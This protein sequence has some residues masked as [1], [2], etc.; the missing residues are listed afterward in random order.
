LLQAAL[1]RDDLLT[2]T[3]AHDASVATRAHQRTLQ[4][5]PQF[6]EALTAGGW[7]LSVGSLGGE[8]WVVDAVAA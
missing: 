2:S 8:G 3:I 6:S 1:L 7:D 5:F 4:L